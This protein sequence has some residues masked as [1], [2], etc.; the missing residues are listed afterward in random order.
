MEFINKPI[1]IS[2]EY[3]SKYLMETI[4]EP[5]AIS[6][7]YDPNWIFIYAHLLCCLCCFRLRELLTLKGH[8]DSVVKLKGLDIETIQ[9]SYTV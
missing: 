4:N 2:L 1:G 5:I 3:D 9:G 8:V 6:P 7:E